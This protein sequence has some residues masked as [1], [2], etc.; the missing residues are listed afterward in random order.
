MQD[1]GKPETEPRARNDKTGLPPSLILPVMPSAWTSS[2]IPSLNATTFS[3]C[4]GRAEGGTDTGAT[5]PSM[6]PAMA[7]ATTTTSTATADTSAGADDDDNNN[8]R[9]ALF[10]YGPDPDCEMERH[11]RA[12]FAKLGLEYV[13]PEERWTL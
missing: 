11:E 13:P 5:A 8:D 2:S 3:N 4:D 6:A 7:P 9:P 12:V 1:S 10:D